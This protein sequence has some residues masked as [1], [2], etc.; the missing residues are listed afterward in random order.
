MV[1]ILRTKGMILRNVQLKLISVRLD[2]RDDVS[3]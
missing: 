1:S 2:E 3:K